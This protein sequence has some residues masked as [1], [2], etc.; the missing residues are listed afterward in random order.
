MTEVLEFASIP[1]KSLDDEKPVYLSLYPP[2]VGEANLVQHRKVPTI[3]YFH[4][5]GLTVGNRDSWHPTWLQRRAYTSGFAFIV[6]NYR[7]IP[8]S[9]GHSILSDIKDL[10]AFLVK[11]DLHAV[12]RSIYPHAQ[13]EA[14]NIAIDRDAIIVAGS[15]AGGLCAYLAAV[16]CNDPRPR[17]VLSMYGMGGNFFMPHY[18]VPKKEVFFRGRE[19]LEPSNFSEYLYP[20]AKALGEMTDSPLQYHSNEYHI[21]GYPANPRMLLARLY[22]QMGVFLDYYTD[23]HDPSLSARLGKIFLKHTGTNARNRTALESE[24][25]MMEYAEAI[26]EHHHCLFP[27]LHVTTNWPPTIL[28]HGTA[29][30]A[31]LFEESLNLGYALEKAGVP[32]LTYR[33]NGEEHSFDYN[34]DAEEKYGEIFNTIVATLQKWVSA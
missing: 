7:L 30:T 32:V 27:Q 21:P 22:L 19:L 34:A 28:C 2:K 20:R 14:Y 33:I 1:F 23:C 31:V 10:F 9:T 5:G 25:E 8:P 29:D 11:T 12:V 16:H 13:A 26:P 4:G 17:A 6:P 18:F 3:I 15:S 24:H